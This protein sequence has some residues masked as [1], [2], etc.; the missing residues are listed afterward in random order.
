MKLTSTE[1]IRFTKYTKFSKI[2]VNKASIPLEMLRN[3]VMQLIPKKC[4]V[5]GADPGPWM[6]GLNCP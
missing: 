2:V 6:I 5:L 3:D 4:C 1:R